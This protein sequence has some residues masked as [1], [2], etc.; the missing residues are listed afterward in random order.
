MDKI[1]FIVVFIAFVFFILG[2]VSQK[3]EAKGL[4]DGKLAEPGNSPNVV[5]SEENVQPERAI[6]PISGSLSQ[7]KTAIE[8]TGGTITSES[9][10]YLS[11]TYMSKVFKFVDDVEIRK[12]SDTLWHIR[13]S[14]RVGYSDRGVNRKR[15]ETIRAAL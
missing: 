14:S 10:S 5:S 15:V 11:A 12:E 6:S 8:T 7:I 1:L 13:S 3:G 2:L 4:V 9:G